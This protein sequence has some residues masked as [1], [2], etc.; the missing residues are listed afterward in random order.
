MVSPQG[1]F[2]AVGTRTGVVYW[3]SAETGELLTIQNAGHRHDVVGIAFSNDG[4]Q[5]VSVAEDGTV[6]LWD[7]PSCRL[8]TSFKG[9][10][11]GA[12]AVAFS[13][14]GH[15]FATGGTSREAVKLWDVFTRRAL[16]TLPGQG[17]LFEFVV[18]SQDG[19][20]LAA[21]SSD[22]RLHLWR[23][24]SWEE[25]RAAEHEPRDKTRS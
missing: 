6:A 21:C 5:A 10:M 17:L 13:P 1:R 23:A 19:R 7:P 8:L 18:F 15:R 11:Q 14:D 12:H 4:T 16:L 20:W 9:H 24:P 25:I 22:G 3:R 2:L